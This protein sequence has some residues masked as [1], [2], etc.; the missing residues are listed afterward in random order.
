MYIQLKFKLK[1]TSNKDRDFYEIKWRFGSK[2][3]PSAF[4]LLF[5]VTLHTKY[6]TD[7]LKFTINDENR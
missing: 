1:K 7:D 6:Q 4:I 5:I 3:K 2:N